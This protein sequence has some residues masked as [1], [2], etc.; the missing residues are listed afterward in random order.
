[1][2]NLASVSRSRDLSRTAPDVLLARSGGAAGMLHGVFGL[3]LTAAFLI[4][5]SAN[6][7][8]LPD[9]GHPAAGYDFLKTALPY[10]L[11][12]FLL[13]SLAVALTPVFVR[14]LDVR[15][16]PHAPELS[17]IAA[18]L[19]YLGFGI[20]AIH[21]AGFVSLLQ[22]IA[23]GESRAAVETAIP[24]LFQ[25]AGALGVAAGLFIGLYLAMVSWITTRRGG[26]PAVF[27]YFGL[28][29]GVV[30]VIG[31]TAGIHGVPSLL[32]STWLIAVGM[33]IWVR[34]EPA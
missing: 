32:P 9:G 17:S 6:H 25:L 20:L 22:G 11:P 3:G 31:T 10:L 24:G 2:T 13:A 18:T 12:I 16:R 8:Q 14:A 29:G 15:L 7:L 19:G 28:L 30:A 4:T 1:M 34:P 33:F 27:G 26:L 21:N 23:S 5:A